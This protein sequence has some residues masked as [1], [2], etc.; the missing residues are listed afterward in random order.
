MDAKHSIYTVQTVNKTFEILEIL[1]DHS[2]TY[3]FAQ[4]SKSIGLTRNKTFRLLSTLCEMG[5]VEKDPHG[6]N[7]QLGFSSVLLAQKFLLNSSVVNYAHP[8]MEELVRKHDEA[9]YMTVINGD[10]VLFLDM[11][12]CAHQVKA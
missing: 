5:L 4:L 8:V 9:V 2:T 10:E 1:A 7:Y 6:G 3:S 12:D 11:V